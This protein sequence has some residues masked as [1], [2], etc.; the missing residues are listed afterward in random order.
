MQR[1]TRV[2]VLWVEDK[3]YQRETL[4]QNKMGEGK[5]KWIIQYT[6]S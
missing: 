4:K 5:R 3:K 6:Q 2:K 1:Y